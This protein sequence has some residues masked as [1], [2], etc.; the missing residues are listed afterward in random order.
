MIPTVAPDILRPKE[1][2]DHAEKLAV[3]REPLQ[4]VVLAIRD[5]DLLR[6]D[7]P[8]GVRRD[9]L[10]RRDAELAKA[11]QELS[12]R[13]EDMHLRV[14]ITVRDDDAAIRQDS[15]IGWVAER[16]ARLVAGPQLLQ[17]PSGEIV[18][19]DLVGVAVRDVDPVRIANRDHVRVGDLLTPRGQACALGRELDHRRPRP[20]RL[21]VTPYQDEYV[22]A[23]VDCHIRDRRAG[24]VR[25]QAPK[26]ALHAIPSLPHTNEQA[27]QHTDPPCDAC[28]SPIYPETPSMLPFDLTLRHALVVAEDLIHHTDV[29]VRNGKIATIENDLEPGIEDVD[30]TSLLLL[31]GGVDSHVHVAQKL[32]SGAEIADDFDT[33][34]ASA[35]A[36]GT[37]TMIAFIMQPRGGSLAGAAAKSHGL[38][39]KSR[40][41]YS[42]HLT[43]TDP[44]TEVLERDLPELI[45]AGH[46]SIKIF[47]ANAST[48]LTDAQILPV[49]ATAR[50]HGA[51]VCV[52]AE[53]HELIDW[54][55]ARLVA[56]GFTKPAA[57][58]LA[59]PMIA[60]REATHRVIA[61]AEALNTPLQIFHISGHDSAEEVA[62]A[63]ARGVQVWAETCTHYLVLTADDLDRPGFEGAK[64]MFAPPARTAAD[65][66][67]L[68]RRIKDGTITVISSDHSPLNYDHPRGKMFAGA[69][70]PFQKIPNGVPGLAAR[71]P[72]VFS[73]GVAKGRIDLRTLVDLVSTTPARLFG[74]YPQKGVIAVGSDADLVLWDPAAHR[75]L[76]NADMHHGSDYT[77]FEGLAV[78]GAVRSTYLR[79]QL[80]FDGAAVTAR[81]GTG[82]FLPRAPYPAIRP[83]GR[84]PAGFDP[85]R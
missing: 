56:Q 11:A 58:A 48:R 2:G 36:G 68:W 41:D 82:A 9:K 32:S 42:F 27:F 55:T 81:P 28:P 62:R 45:A 47:M 57:L 29:G 7:G 14:P 54:M 59:K 50:T 17:Q 19:A 12:S 65:Q 25:S 60:E 51:L 44:T 37:T 61:L 39:R 49:L 6:A 72:I 40:A 23:P 10:A 43:I 76:R 5:G 8:D 67:D 74:L 63:Q 46:R 78:T 22:A 84:F 26:G 71:L 53:H 34:S 1:A 38:A 33:G 69:D 35:L 52:H 24:Q 75:T 3:D 66:A 4:P 64:F 15:G 13:R 30:A 70:A 18:N 80:A 77:P 31:P 16:S 83:S 79:G 85:F 73:E 20:A 21:R